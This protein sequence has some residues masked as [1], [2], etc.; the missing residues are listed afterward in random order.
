MERVER[1]EP[2]CVNGINVLNVRK[3]CK[4]LSQIQNCEIVEDDWM[5]GKQLV[6][7]FR[8]KRKKKRRKKCESKTDVKDTWE[9]LFG[10]SQNESKHDF[11]G[12]AKDTWERLFGESQSENKYDFE[13]F[14]WDKEKTALELTHSICRFP[15]REEDS[16]VSSKNDSVSVVNGSRNLSEEF[17]A[18]VD[19][20]IQELSDILSDVRMTESVNVSENRTVNMNVRVNEYERPQTRSR[21]P[22][23]EYEW[24]MSKRM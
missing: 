23:P 5:K 8:K 7:V 2:S 1:G 4:Y 12:F 19:K 21:G 11:E 13:G 6:L 15:L 16:I 14:W 17:S 20:V 22:V 18:D 3:G 9:R 24:V 10:E